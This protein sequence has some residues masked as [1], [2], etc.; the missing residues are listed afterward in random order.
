MLSSV[1]SNRCKMAGGR[2]FGEMWEV[3]RER[4]GEPEKMRT[5]RERRNIK[6]KMI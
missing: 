1:R 4:K 3:G 2:A 5:K 6:W